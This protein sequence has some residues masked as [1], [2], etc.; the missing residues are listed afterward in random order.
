MYYS[1]HSV[2]FT[3]TH[4]TTEK[5]LSPSQN[6]HAVGAFP[7]FYSFCGQIVYIHTCHLHNK[8]LIMRMY[9]NLKI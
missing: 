3:D 1:M 9:F 2:V 6:P 8:Y 4:Y 5:N 7:N